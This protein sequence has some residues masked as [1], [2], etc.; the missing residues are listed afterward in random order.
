MMFRKIRSTDDI[1]REK[2]L[3]KNG[4]IFGYITGIAFANSIGLT[5]QVPMPYIICSNE[6]SLE[7]ED[8]VLNGFRIILYKP[9]CPINNY[10]AYALQ[11]LDLMTDVL[12]IAELEGDKLRK[13]LLRYITA[14]GLAYS[15][16]KPY[17]IY[18]PKITLDNILEIKLFA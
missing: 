8:I 6:A 16:L 1:I 15:D 12:D 7:F 4:S 10:N 3:V 18:Y 9:K 13:A 11:F 14:R 5:T 2:Y 17:F